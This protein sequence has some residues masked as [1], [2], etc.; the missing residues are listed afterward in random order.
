MTDRPEPDRIASA[1]VEPDISIVMPAYNEEEIVEYTVRRLVGAFEAAGHR[2]ELIAV[3]NGSTDRTGEILHALAA[4]FPQVVPHRVE[5]NEGYG[6]GVTSGFTRCRAKWVGWIPADGQVDAE[7]V[8]RLYDAIAATDGRTLAKVRRRFR[9]D[10]LLRKIVSISYNALVWILWPRLGSLDLN[11]V[12]KIMSRD[13][14]GAMQITSKEWFL[15]PEI[16]I[17]AHYMGIRVLE[18]NVF[19]RMRGAGLSHVRA[20]TCLDFFR[21]LLEFRFSPR[22]RAWRR[23][24]TVPPPSVPRKSNAL[25]L[26]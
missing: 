14:L 6:N 16:M 18:L 17:K 21:G 25:A 12:P 19:A 23:E 4:E 24:T 20:S 22:V 1:S 13:V 2:L 3:D 9:M 11:G 15:D 10:G 8:V 5:V 26:H 7:D